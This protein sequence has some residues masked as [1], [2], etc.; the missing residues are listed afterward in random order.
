MEPWQRAVLILCLYGFF[1]E[2]R[3]SEAFLT[4]YLKSDFKNLTENEVNNQ[5]YP[6]WTY[7]Y[8]A[9]LFL[10]LLTTDLLR[11]NPLIIFEGVM[12]LI[13]WS[14]LIWGEGVMA[15]QLMQFVYGFATA[16]EI[17]Y[18][19]YIYLVVSMDKY[20][21]LT[22]LI[23]AVL[24]CGRFTAGVVGQLVISLHAMNYLQLNYISMS[25]V[26]VAFIMSL[27]LP[28]ANKLNS[29]KK[30]AD[31]AFRERTV[32]TMS[33]AQIST[34]DVGVTA[35]SLAEEM[36]T[37]R[38]CSCCTC[39]NQET[40]DDSSF[41]DVSLSETRCCHRCNKRCKFE[42][43]SLFYDVIKCYT[44]PNMLKWSLWW[45]FATCG[46][47]QVG[48]FGQNLWDEISPSRDNPKIYNGGVE[49]ITTL[50]GAVMAFATGFIKADWQKYG[51][52][53][54]FIVTALDCVCLLVM[55]QATNIW[56]AYAMY[57]VFRAFYQPGIT[58]ASF[59]IAS[60][61][62][63][64][65]HGLVFG[66]NTFMALLLETIITAVVVDKRG[67]DTPIRTQFVVYGC[68]FGI[69]SAVFAGAAIYSTYRRLRATEVDNQGHTDEANVQSS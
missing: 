67:L 58:A 7:S 13:T 12:Y 52:L 19:C 15:M 33:S 32:S 23:R 46:F 47:F 10:V 38:G 4:P 37:P 48:N 49:A 54:L 8:L 53:L 62:K 2:L 1:K 31:D 9:A 44:N 63:T 27:I 28:C 59:Q 35:D 34:S 56:L 64:D 29:A 55:S 14:L 26:G 22:G 25:C 36:E 39:C 42:M 43:R 57:I 24:L 65:R 41:V 50:T 20:Q 60:Y 17:S 18:S 51:E 5:I 40:D 21:K 30:D 61:L 69:I 16:T 11:H 3:P 6:V 66:C 45:A 68:Y